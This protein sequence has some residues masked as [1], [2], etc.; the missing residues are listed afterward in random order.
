MA[1][2]Q[3]FQI[4]GESFTGRAQTTI[5]GARFIK[6]HS[7]TGDNNWGVQAC[8]A[9]AAPCGVSSQDAASGT[10]VLVWSAPGII[11]EVEVGTGGVTAGQE[12]ESDAVGKAITQS[13]GKVAGIAMADASA[14]ALAPIKLLH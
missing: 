1:S 13:T 9:G 3:P 10:D 5:V 4:P 12:V 11:T 14:G 6:P 8:T 2:S 7:T